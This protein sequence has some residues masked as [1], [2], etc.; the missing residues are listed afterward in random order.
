VESK[1]VKSLMLGPR[2][3][4]IGLSLL[5]YGVSFLLPVISGN[6]TRET[7]Y[8]FRVFAD[9][10]CIALE[11]HEP[12]GRG[13]PVI[14]WAANPVFW[15]GLGLL[16]FRHQ[17]LACLAGV[18]AM[19][20]GAAPALI[21][22]LGPPGPGYWVWLASFATLAV[23][24]VSRTSFRLIMAVTVIAG[25]LFLL[26]WPRVFFPPVEVRQKAYGQKAFRPDRD[27]AQPSKFS[28]R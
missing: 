14:A 7:A 10:F 24:S 4:V 17:W 23:G 12:M 2:A 3:V 18:I 28:P 1:I 13:V 19:L 25:V 9:T 22:V 15:L 27:I 20:F 21:I 8:G 26:S 5:V 6:Q 11:Q 16:Y